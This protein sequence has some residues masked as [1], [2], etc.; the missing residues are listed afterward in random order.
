[1]QERYTTFLKKRSYD[2]L[3]LKIAP[4]ANERYSPPPLTD[5]LAVLSSDSID[6]SIGNRI[7]SATQSGIALPRAGNLTTLFLESGL[8]SRYS[9]IAGHDIE[10]RADKQVD[11]YLQ[12]VLIGVFGYCI[13]LRALGNVLRD[14]SN[15]LPLLRDENISHPADEYKSPAVNTK[16]GP[17][18]FITIRKLLLRELFDAR[19]ELFGFGRQDVVPVTDPRHEFFHLYQAWEQIQYKR[20]PIIERERANGAKRPS[21]SQ[22]A[23]DSSSNMLAQQL[24]LSI[25]I[26]H[27][28]PNSYCQTQPTNE[29]DE[30]L[31]STSNLPLDSLR[32]AQMARP[33][34]RQTHDDFEVAFGN[35]LGP[36]SPENFVTCELRP[37]GHALFTIVQEIVPERDTPCSG[38]YEHA[39]GAFNQ[40]D[41]AL[42]RVFQEHNGVS[43]HDKDKEDKISAIEVV[44]ALCVLYAPYTLWAKERHSSI[45]KKN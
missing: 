35:P 19:D 23:F 29:Q 40:S 21:A 25:D 39:A 6:V 7:R 24:Q 3:G 37:T 41:L 11:R 13:E 8:R 38:Y 44:T 36:P 33:F 32:N 4:K 16:L 2:G 28:F 31:L 1:M 34:A 14:I 20:A 17:P 5:T 43:I 30:T 15:G 26:V 12:D 22:T 42:Y 10:Q 27:Q 45:N 9:K 18:E